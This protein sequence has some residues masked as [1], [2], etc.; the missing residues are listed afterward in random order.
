M[1]ISP[2]CCLKEYK[3]VQ[4]LRKMI[5]SFVIKLNTCLLCGPAP[6]AV[7]ASTSPWAYWSDT[8][9]VAALR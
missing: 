6:R 2:V 5:W 7:V 4:T 8:G 9:L 1:G 3:M